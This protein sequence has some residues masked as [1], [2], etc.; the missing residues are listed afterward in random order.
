MTAE[1]IKEIAITSAQFYYDYLE[2]NEKGIQLV[3]VFSIEYLPS[4]DFLMKLRLSAKLFDVEA[5]FFKL[6]SRNKKYDTTE[7]KIIEYDA[8]KNVL[9]IKIPPD[10]VADFSNLGTDEL[11]VIS[12][13]K[14]L[15]LRV[16]TWY[17]IN[18]LKVLIPTNT[19]S[20]NFDDLEFKGN[21]PSENQKASISNIFTKPFSYIWGAPGTGKTQFVLANSVLHYIKHSKRVAVIAPTNNAIE[22]VLSGIL[23]VTD[24]VGIE[25]KKIIRLG[26]PSRK[27][28]ES[29]PEV[30]EEKGIQKK[31]DEIDKQIEILERIVDYQSNLRT[32]QQCKLK[33]DEF[34]GIANLY[35]QSKHFKSVY[36][37]S[38]T[39]HRKIEI[40]LKYFDEELQKLNSQKSKLN[41]SISSLI[42]QLKKIF[43]SKRSAQEIE[44]EN[45][46]LKI[47]A[48]RK[49]IDL[50]NYSLNEAQTNIEERRN[51]L[52]SSDK[53]LTGYITKLK[54]EFSS[55]R[56]IQKIIDE[57]KPTNW[58]MVK[59]NL[60]AH[61]NEKLSE[62][63]IDKHLFTEYRN[64]SAEKLQFKLDQIIASRIK[65][66]LDSTEERLNSVS[67]IACTLDGYIGR[68]ADS[69]L[70]V[71]HIFLDEAGY[72]NVIKALTLFGQ[73]IPVCFLG[74]HMQLPP[75]CEINDSLIAEGNGFA[76]MFIWS[77]S[78]IYLESLFLNRKSDALQQ[79]IEG[80][81]FVPKVISKTALNSTFRF[82]SNL[83]KILGKHVYDNN[84]VSSNGTGETEIF[85]INA[86]KIRSQNTRTSLREVE[87]IKTLVNQLRTEGDHEFVILT[88][89][90][91]QLQLIGKHLPIERNELKIL[92]VHGS[93][94]REWDI[95]ILSVVDTLDKWFCD[96]KQPLSKGKNLVN[97]AVSR[98]KKSLVIVCDTEYWGSQNGQLI[99][100][101][102]RIGKEITLP[103]S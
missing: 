1:E 19:P 5:V 84:F 41:S 49:E 20:I 92:T 64:D 74:D 69:N 45:I 18:G 17:E 36:E 79:Y 21:T 87:E 39:T 7:I 66:A 70:N 98:A 85:F 88:P 37:N 12:D 54:L 95:V 75:V 35:E 9:L 33:L 78:A 40:D 73:N 30:C 65:L 56:S 2:E 63:D 81:K 59:S 46:V 8:D 77:Q 43:I 99:S 55:D 100:D 82:G 101:L 15:I 26:T 24:K 52:K 72:A 50:L 62:L 86:K 31:L 94:G 13:L 83:S 58:E 10:K 76:D 32:I 25:R 22:Q 28:A 71:Q 53:T 47:E 4:K 27:F 60:T 14:F 29:Y 61:L 57:L 96:S 80:H 6:E 16:K 68:F 34:D 48:K 51:D 91:N 11:K 42:H 23:K 102:I 97:T 103:K 44:L 67:V 89:Y 38:K 3:D 93:Q 90:R